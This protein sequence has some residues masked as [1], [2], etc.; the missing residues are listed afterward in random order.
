MNFWS[1]HG[2]SRQDDTP[3]HC[4]W[5]GTCEGCVDQKNTKHDYNYLYNGTGEPITD[6]EDIANLNYVC[7]E[8]MEELSK[9]WQR[10]IDETAGREKF[11]Q[12]FFFV[13]RSGAGGAEQN[14]CCSHK[15]IDDLRDN[16]GMAL[17]LVNRCPSC[18][19][20]LRM[21][22]CYMTCH[23]EHSKFIQPGTIID[24][25]DPLDN[26]T[27]QVIEKLDYYIGSSYVDDLYDSCNEV[28]NPSSNSYVI[29]TFCGQWGELC[30]S[31][32]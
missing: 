31:Q 22:F 15:Q 17:G 8:L 29:T 2:H 4:V 18:A 12:I 30:D 28:T 13:C 16:F 7:P 11:S 21:V 19:R 24:V 14:F 32:K 23:P 1:Q 3:G 25:V 6:E 5:Y 27:K 26:Q 9:N 10:M 20:N